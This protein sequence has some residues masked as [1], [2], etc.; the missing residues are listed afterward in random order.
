MKAGAGLLVAILAATSAAVAQTQTLPEQVPTRRPDGTMIYPGQA[1]GV[2]GPD[3]ST[4]VRPD[5]SHVR[6]GT[7]GAPVGT[8]EA[9]PVRRPDGSVVYPPPA[10]D[11]QR[12]PSSAVGDSARGADERERRRQETQQAID[13]RTER[14]RREREAA[15]TSPARQVPSTTLPR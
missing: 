5:G 1:G 7:A 2:S 11:R 4:V 10:T 6:P 13:E 12:A 3:Q 9:V 8:S 15:A 14:A